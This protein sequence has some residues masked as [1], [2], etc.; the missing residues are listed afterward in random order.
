MPASRD[1]ERARPSCRPPG[2][3]F[4][5]PAS[6]PGCHRPEASLTP[7]R[8][9]AEANL[10]RLAILFTLVAF[11]GFLAETASGPSVQSMN[12][13]QLAGALLYVGIVSFL[14]FGGIVYLLCRLGHLRRRRAFSPP[15]DADLA[16]ICDSTSARVTVLVPSYR[17]EARVVRQA[18]LSAALQTY[19]HRRVVLLIDDP[20]NPS[21]AEE[22]ARLAAA[23]RLPHE[24]A[25]LLSGP[26]EQLSRECV[27]AHARS[28]LGEFDARREAY[29]LAELYD[30]L[31][32]WF[33]EQAS[34]FEHGDH[35]D[36]LF[37]E[38]T[39]HAPARKHRA[40][41]AQLRHRDACPDKAD[42]L[43]HYRWLH[44]AFRVEVTSFE[45]K[46]FQNLSHAANKA[47]NLNSYISLLGRR[48]AEARDPRGI[49]LRA[50]SASEPGMDIPENEY[51]LTLDADSVLS[52]D[53]TATL[54]KFME[55]AGNERIAVVQTPYSSVPGAP[56]N[57]ERIAGATTDIQYLIHQ[58]FTRHR[59][60][61]W[62]G[63]NAI[64]RKAALDDIATDAEDIGGGLAMRKF[65]QDRT[66][67]EDT[68]SSVD[69]VAR[70]WRLH[71]YP[72]RLSY[73]ATP[74]DYGA[75]LIQRRRWA[76][77]GLLILP[78]LFRLRRR[79]RGERPS[80]SELLMRF[81]YLSSIAGVNV[82]L[83][84]LLTL[85]FA[86]WFSNPW[87]PLTALPYFALYAH[88]LRLAG[89]QR[90]D[91]L[92]VYAL[93]LLLVPA[94]LGGVLKSLHQAISG[95]ATAFR[96]TP[97]VDH[98]TAVPGVYVLAPCIGF[99]YLCWGFAFETASGNW[100][101]ALAAGVNAA[102]LGY[103]VRTFIGW[104]NAREDLFRHGAAVLEAKVSEGVLGSLRE[105]IDR[106]APFG[107]LINTARGRSSRARWASVARQLLIAVAMISVVGA[108]L[109]V[110]G[111]V[112]GAGLI[113][114]LSSFSLLALTV[115]TGI[116]A[117]L[118][119]SAK[120]VQLW[121]RGARL[122]R[123]ANFE[124]RLLEPLAYT[125]LALA[126]AVAT[127]F[128]LRGRDAYEVLT[129]TEGRDSATAALAW[130]AQGAAEI[131]APAG[132]PGL[133]LVALALVMMTSTLVPLALTRRLV[134]SASAV[135]LA[136]LAGWLIALGVSGGELL[137]GSPGSQSTPPSEASSRTQNPPAP[138]SAQ[139]HPQ[140]H[141]STR[142]VRTASPSPAGGGSASGTSSGSG[143]ASGTGSGSGSDTSNGSGSGTTDS[144]GSN[145]KPT[146]PQPVQSP[147]TPSTPPSTSQDQGTTPTTEAPTDSP[148]NLPSGSEL[149]GQLP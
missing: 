132:S 84:L 31:A 114:G 105:R 112:S 145:P 75:L 107:E 79:D 131:N 76:N 25:E 92:R 33:E 63:A 45:R 59:A 1:P 126:L 11:A 67:I 134:R 104:R 24:V 10:S 3:T 99:A 68:E 141:Q 111:L 17:E 47:M 9:S 61:F 135:P 120:L 40:T 70:G 139:S 137:P 103:A 109:G 142:A 44:S 35:T 20:P 116:L 74:P 23:R 86:D 128:V 108:M 115:T 64:L 72:E 96:R 51:V 100:F 123:R 2:A 91:V 22:R 41:A 12:P 32:V 83:V 66:V 101:R 39:L 28:V 27:R 58:G 4:T 121:S 14:V 52:P 102:F 65:I 34:L 98:R 118:V 88:D 50:A 143:T 106:L 21:G 60:T 77:G 43:R 26:R 7:G 87:L 56:G 71:N 119:V 148:G 69:L 30:R 130:I 89:Y 138:A 46:R 140:S 127:A 42:L 129:V 16:A 124:R 48:V 53:Y 85:P 5:A 6:Q 78:K 125:A 62:V 110:V 90:L 95:K 38:Q 55:D 93:N 29:H 113:Q 146:A 147:S 8:L 80:I 54:V 97:K 73:T 136:L 49:V 18:L 81:H 94:N 117:F 13:G 15:T 37:A 82:G 19:P 57:V 149:P 122:G 144:Q 133:I 36:V